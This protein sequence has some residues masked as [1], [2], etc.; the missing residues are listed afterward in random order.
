[1]PGAHQQ[2]II[3]RLVASGMSASEFLEK[4]R[5]EWPNLRDTWK[6]YRERGTDDD[7]EALLTYAAEVSER[8]ASSQEAIRAESI[9]FWQA[10][11]YS[12]VGRETDVVACLERAHASDP[13]QF[14]TRYALQ[15]SLV[16]A[17]RYAEAEPHIRWCLARRPAD[18]SLSNAL[19]AI[20][21]HRLSERE[22]VASNPDARVN[23]WQR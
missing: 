21:K 16:A 10:M 6:N 8:Q 2:Q 17:H 5:P 18:K 1:V 14:Y 9:W 7:L 15:K 12:D 4:F 11:M 22:V 23:T 20:A 13:R 19:K 3:Y